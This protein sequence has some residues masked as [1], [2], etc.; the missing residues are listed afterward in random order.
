M[1]RCASTERQTHP[2]WPWGQSGLL[3]ACGGTV[4]PSQP[5]SSLARRGEDV[6]GGQ[7]VSEAVGFPWH[8]PPGCHSHEAGSWGCSVIAQR[9]VGLPAREQGLPGLP[10]VP[11]LGPRVLQSG[12]VPVFV[13]Q[14]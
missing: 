3:E 8:P 9:L 1:G 7:V 13:F 4:P 6:G 5:R 2:R 12:A 11:A 10:S 14:R